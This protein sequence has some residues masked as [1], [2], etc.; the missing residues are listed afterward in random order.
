MSSNLINSPEA[1]KRF[2]N[3]LQEISGSMTRI[4]GERDLIKTITS[5]LAEEF[6]IDKK[7]VARMAKTYHKQSFKDTVAADDE[8]TTIYQIVTGEE[9][10]QFADDAPYNGDADE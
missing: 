10:A 6:Q 5:D 8:F 9:A 3:K 1:K 4:E 7:I 2:N